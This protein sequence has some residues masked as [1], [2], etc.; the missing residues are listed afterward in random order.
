[1]DLFQQSNIPRSPLFNV[2]QNY[3]SP[4]SFL[5]VSYLSFSYI[6]TQKNLAG[7]LQQE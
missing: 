7:E 5:D 1:M 2:L 3:Y 6:S 4:G